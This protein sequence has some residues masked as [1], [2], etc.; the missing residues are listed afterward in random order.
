MFCLENPSRGCNEAFNGSLE[1][2]VFNDLKSER[3]GGGETAEVVC[4][5]AAVV[6]GTVIR[7]QY[8]I[9]HEQLHIFFSTNQTMTVVLF[10]Y[11]SHFDVLFH[12]FPYVNR[13]K[14]G[15][16]YIFLRPRPKHIIL[17]PAPQKVD[18]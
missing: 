6:S 3:V 17:R 16:I 13:P 18:L 12:C 9:Q 4:N 8:R 11:M 15:R 10:S 2:H 14:Q 5:L 7:L 1:C